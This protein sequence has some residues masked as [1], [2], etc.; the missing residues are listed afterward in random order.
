MSKEL[1]SMDICL[2]V[3]TDRRS[4][5]GT[6]EMNLTSVHEDAVLTPG[7]AQWVRIRHFH[8]PWYW[9]WMR[10]RFSISV[11]VV[12]PGSCS[13]DSTPSLGISI[14]LRCGPKKQKEVGAENTSLIK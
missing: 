8:E 7:L 5:F 6:A 9:S 3:G 1:I 12:Y 13:S 10:L 11:A 14:C 2:E 4:H